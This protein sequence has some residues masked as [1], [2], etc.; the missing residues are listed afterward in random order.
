MTPQQ[1]KLLGILQGSFQ[2]EGGTDFGTFMKKLATL[3]RDPNNKLVQMGNSA[4]LLLRKEPTTVEVHTFST[5]PPNELVQ[6]FQ[7]LAKLL[8]NQ[9]MRK[10][11][12]YAENPAYASIAKQTGLPVRVGHTRKTLGGQSKAMYTFEVTL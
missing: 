12:T 2:Q 7:G 11:I 8:K 9:G 6:A 5:S 10:A 1:Q 4:F 3:L